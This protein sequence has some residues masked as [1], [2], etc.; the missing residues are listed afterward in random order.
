M[1]LQPDVDTGDVVSRQVGCKRA[2]HYYDMREASPFRVT[3]AAHTHE[4]HKQDVHYQCHNGHYTAID[5]G[6]VAVRKDVADEAYDHPEEPIARQVLQ[7]IL[8]E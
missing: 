2:Q 6:P 1:G 7:V 4:K 5:E 8:S 3:A